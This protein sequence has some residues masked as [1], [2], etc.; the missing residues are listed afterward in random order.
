MQAYGHRL[1]LSLN[2]PVGAPE[3]D[4]VNNRGSRVSEESALP[5]LESSTDPI[6]ASYKLIPTQHFS[7]KL[8]YDG[9]KGS[10]AT[11]PRRVL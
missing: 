5:A 9:G 10:R 8:F 6:C 2:P 7:F 11:P 4:V 1:W 3:K